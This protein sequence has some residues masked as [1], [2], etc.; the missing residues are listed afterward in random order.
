LESAAEV[1]FETLVP[2]S[3]LSAVLAALRSTHPYEEPAFDLSQLAA[4]PRGIG[5]GRIGTLPA[6]VL[7]TKLIE[8]IKKK[9]GLEFLLVSGS[10]RER[11][12]KVAICAGAG[13][14]LLDD[15]ISQGARLYLTGEL[16]HHDAIKAS[17]AGINVICTLHS[18]SER[19]VLKVLKSQLEKRLPSLRFFL[20]RRDRDPFDIR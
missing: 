11:V 12:R 1:R 9:L 20:S 17:R 4:V 10:Q 2:I 5:Q 13:G 6:P 15:A 3:K 16:R 18:N 19:G 7:M 14:D 8:R